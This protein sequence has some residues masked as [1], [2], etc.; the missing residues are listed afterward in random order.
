[1]ASPVSPLNGYYTK[2]GSGVSGTP[3]V[4]FEE[5]KEF[6]HLQFAAWPETISKLGARCAKAFGSS[7]TPGPGRFVQTR[8]G[9]FLRVEPLKWWL[10]STDDAPI[11]ELNVPAT[12]G[13]AL[14]I[15]HSRAWLKISGDKAQQLLNQFLPIDLREA[16]FSTG[17]VASTAFHHTGVTVWR[18]DGEFNLLLPRS[19]AVSLWEMLQES[20]LQYGLEVQ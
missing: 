15:S 4:V 8:S 19:F 12:E 5:V 2:G 3:A 11:P 18:T 1:M 7:R 14:D 13:S 17:S 6:H 16:A 10:I 9:V 20:A